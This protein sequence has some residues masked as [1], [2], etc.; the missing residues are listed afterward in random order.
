M[1]L[2]QRTASE[3]DDE[4]HT[5]L[6]PAT[7]FYRIDDPS[8]LRALLG[9]PCTTLIALHSKAFPLQSPYTK[10][11]GHQK[12]YANGLQKVQERYVEKYNKRYLVEVA[13]TCEG[14]PGIVRL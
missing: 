2:R 13:A 1:L 3:N 8:T 6:E 10:P 12:S 11:N 14:V 5:P 9:N 4:T 7:S